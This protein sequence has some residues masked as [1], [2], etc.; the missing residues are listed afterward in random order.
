MYTILKHIHESVTIDALE[1]YL[2]P[3]I[4]GSF[5]QCRGEL[6]AIIIIQLYEKS[7]IPVERHALI[8]VCSEPVKQRLIKKLNKQNFIDELG[9][10]QSV[11][12]AEYVIRQI[13]ND[14]RANSQARLNDRAE[15]RRN[16]RR[17]LGLKVV[18]V[19]EKDFTSGLKKGMKP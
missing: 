3:L 2:R 9:Q 19:E 14:K 6:K 11:Q 17:R 12:A 7:G 8:R 10:T 1:C 4:K 18:H 5:F 13:M 15:R 16:E